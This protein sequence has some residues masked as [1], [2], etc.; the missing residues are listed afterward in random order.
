[1][2]TQENPPERRSTAQ[3]RLAAALAEV[4]LPPA[5]EGAQTPAEL[6]WVPGWS[7]IPSW[8]WATPPVDLPEGVEPV[9][10][11]RC[12]ALNSPGGPCRWCSL[13]T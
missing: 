2:N 10:C 7:D 1:M 11:P 6:P 5:R 12:T 4:E 8:V 3:E 9:R 13:E